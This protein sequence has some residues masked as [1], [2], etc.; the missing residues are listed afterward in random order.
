L[1]NRIIKESICYSNDVNCLTP[2]EEVFFYRLV[3]N[4]D[5]YGIFDTRLLKSR[6]YP[7]KEGITNSMIE[8]HL[9]KLFKLGM[10]II[11]ENKDVRYLQLVNWTKH[12]QVRA[13]KSKFPLPDSGGSELITF[14]IN[15]NQMQSNVT[16]I[17]S[18]PI[19]SNRSRISESD[20][21][22]EIPEHFYNNNIA[23]I[24]QFVADDIKNY[25]EDGFEESFILR[26]M[27]EAVKNEKRNWKYISTSLINNGN[28]GIKTVEQ[29]E[30]HE[31]QRVRDKDS[32]GQ[33]QTGT[34]YKDMSD[35]D[36][37]D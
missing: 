26:M 5:D 19:Q 32:K 24:T 31:S 10:V 16:V 17:Q 1:P 13:K 4:C 30:A 23:P 12:Q 37:S 25:L 9:C 11:Y 21:K 7:L 2:E 36:P 8:D 34:H 29:Y 14:D 35:Y 6:L 33:S 28:K 15:G 3:V 18:N 20:I 27:K 22:N